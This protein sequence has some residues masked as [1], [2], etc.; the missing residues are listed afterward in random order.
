MDLL[1]AADGR[2]RIRAVAGVKVRG[3]IPSLK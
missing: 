3:R 1:F 2:V